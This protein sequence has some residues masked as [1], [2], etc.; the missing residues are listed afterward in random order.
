MKLSEKYGWLSVV[1]FMIGILALLTVAFSAGWRFGAG[2][3]GGLCLLIAYA[4]AE[5]SKDAKRDEE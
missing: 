3:I 4:A 1:A 2:A 5:C